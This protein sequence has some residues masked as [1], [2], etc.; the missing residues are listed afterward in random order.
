MLLALLAAM[1]LRE[2]AG[3]GQVVCRSNERSTAGG[4]GDPVRA[5]SHLTIEVQQTAT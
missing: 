4:D 3:N 1:V 2:I 5:E